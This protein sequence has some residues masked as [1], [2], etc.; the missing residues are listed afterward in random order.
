MTYNW[1]S[2]AIR[3][4]E[5][6]MIAMRRDLH[7]HPELAFEEERTARVIADRLSEL[8]LEV[9]AGV[10]KTGVAG[11]LRGG[12]SAASGKAAESARTIMVRADIDALPVQEAND[13]DYCSQEVGK[14]HACG[15]DGHVAIAL[16][17]AA[18]L[19]GRRDDFAGHVVFA[20]Q[21]AEERAAGAVEMIRDGMLENTLPD[22]VIG[23]HLWSPFPAGTVGIKPGPIFA[24]AD[25]FVLR[26]RGR[27]GHG[28]VPQTSVDP[29]VAAAQ[30]VT[31]LQTLVSR[32]IAP[33]HSAVVTIGSIHG[34]SAFN[35]IADEVEMLGTIRT[36]DPADRDLIV[37]RI[38]AL[39][40]G[41][42]ASLRATCDY[43]RD[44]AIPPC[45][46]DP[47]IAELVR[48]AAAATVGEDHIIADC[49]QTVGDDMAYFLEAIPGCYFLVGVGNA[50][51]GITAPHHSARFDIDEA[52]LA[53]GVEVLARSALAYL[54]QS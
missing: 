1:L 51:R 25:G 16:T 15:H 52:G 4:H 17:V 7:R 42:A 33:S 21:P 29:I 13:V 8:G 12:G 14:M 36:Y 46:N 26:V 31:A 45:I 27:G 18:V 23:L 5:D 6:E 49:M 43:S 22:A 38:P 35:V 34:G 53:I 30:I 9:H 24:G 39:T 10:G 3:A 19:A 28:A 54:D 44:I 48:Q 2:A 50:E 41:I 11:L 47:A 20:F 37:Q 40:S 32:E